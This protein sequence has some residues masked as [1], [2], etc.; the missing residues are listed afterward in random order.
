MSHAHAV[1]DQPRARSPLFRDAP[2][3]AATPPAPRPRVLF[4]AKP[5]PERFDDAVAPPAEGA[6]V[7]GGTALLQAQSD[8]PFQALAAMRWR[9]EPWP[10]PVAGLTALERGNLAHA[11]L[12]TFWDETRDHAS[13][14][15]LV[16]DRP[17]YDDVRARAVA[18]AMRRKV[19]RARWARLPTI[20]HALERERLDSLVEDWIARVD[21]AR[22]PF[23]VEA[24]ERE[25]RLTPG[26]LPLRFRIDRV[27]RLADGGRAVLDYKTGRVPSIGQWRG[28]RPRALQIALYALALRAEAPDDRVR[29]AVLACTKRGEV[30]PVGLYA[31]D[32]AR[33]PPLPKPGGRGAP[34]VV[35][36]SLLE[37][38]WDAASVALAQAF[39]RGEA[40]VAPNGRGPCAHCGRQAL[41]RVSAANADEEDDDAG[42]E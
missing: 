16:A 29:A 23:E 41:C 20:L 24:V 40:A 9:A 38:E 21:L 12:A 26:G 22:P 10:E 5:A 33:F 37:A 17:R 39:L 7:R 35:D 3:L 14:V 4:D 11:A 18:E 36:W 6:P 2:K 31:D 27:D 8:C 42:T 13:L 19:D 32:D 15:E 1:D 25:A 34:I 30:R 28:E